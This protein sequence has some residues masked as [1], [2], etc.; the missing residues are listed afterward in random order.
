VLC[1]LEC[2]EQ[3]TQFRAQS[4]SEKKDLIPPNKIEQ[5]KA[6]A[7]EKPMWSKNQKPASAKAP[8][9][10]KTLEIYKQ[11]PR[12]KLGLMQQNIA[13]A[14]ARTKLKQVANTSEKNLLIGADRILTRKAT[15]K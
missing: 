5:T 6:L 7:S 10:Q 12:R 11:H 1:V 2:K 4:T 13:E 8:A 9:R 14:R 3:K 15:Q